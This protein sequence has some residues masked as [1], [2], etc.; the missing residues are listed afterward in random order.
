M[1]SDSSPKMAASWCRSLVR[2]KGKSLLFFLIVMTAVMIWTYQTRLAEV[3]EVARYSRVD[4]IQPATLEAKPVSQSL[5]LNAAIGLVLGMSG[6]LVLA[7]LCDRFGRRLLTAADIEQALQ[8]P[9]IATVPHFE[10]WRATGNRWP[11]GQTN[12]SGRR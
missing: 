4:V 12:G 3:L 7:I 8:I 1:R 6:A 2:H 10:R 5:A 9:V 11:V